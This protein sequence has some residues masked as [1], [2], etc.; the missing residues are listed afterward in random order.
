MN[1]YT[2]T[3]FRKNLNETLSVIL[4]K[5]IAGQKTTH[6]HLCIPVQNSC[7]CSGFDTLPFIHHDQL[8]QRLVVF[9]YQRN[10]FQTNSIKY[11]LTVTE[12]LCIKD[13]QRLR[14]Y[15]LEYINKQM[16]QTG[17]E[18]IWFRIFAIESW[19][20]SSMGRTCR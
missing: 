9:Q 17:E 16:V 11:A 10:T 2:H 20:I 1:P 19:F 12:F 15:G 18:E 3:P 8:L 14:I 7:C 5:I 13:I 6:H 4:H